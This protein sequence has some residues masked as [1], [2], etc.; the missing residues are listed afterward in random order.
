MTSSQIVSSPAFPL[1]QYVHVIYR[2]SFSVFGSRRF[3]ICQR[4][5]LSSANF[6][7]TLQALLYIKKKMKFGSSSNSVIQA[8]LKHHH[9]IGF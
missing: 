8:A 7:L 9:S 5:K 6:S 1:S 3:K 2:A 4:Y